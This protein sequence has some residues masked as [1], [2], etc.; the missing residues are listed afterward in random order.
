[1]PY[2]QDVK[3]Y[4]FEMNSIKEFKPKSIENK[5][6]TLQ[7]INSEDF[8]FNIILLLGV[9]LPWK[10][11]TR[12]A[13]TFGEWKTFFKTN[14]TETY[15]AFYE[16]NIIGYFELVILP[17]EVE[18]NYIGILPHHINKKLGGVLLSEATSIAW[19]HSPEKVTVHTCELDH[20]NALKNYIS[21]GFNLIRTEIVNDYYLADEELKEKIG[22]LFLE[23]KNSTINH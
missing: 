18:I 9:G 2:Y 22:S 23:Y 8:F 15:L 20:P 17:L 19:K 5:A 1:M 13:W 10:W 21:R 16:E 6:I 3:T 4:Y 7:K 11:H 14:K 12:L